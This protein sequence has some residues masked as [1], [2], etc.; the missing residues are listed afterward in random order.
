MSFKTSV[1][2]V[3]NINNRSYNAYCLKTRIDR[4][5]NMIIDFAIRRKTI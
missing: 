1:L 3:N 5:L 2:K 4:H